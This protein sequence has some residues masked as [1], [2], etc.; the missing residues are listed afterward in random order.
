M[1]GSTRRD[2]AIAGGLTL[3]VALVAAPAAAQTPQPQQPAQLPSTPEITPPTPS[4]VPPPS[5]SVDARG[6]VVQS[7]CPFEDS[8]IRLQLN[9]VKFARPDGSPLQ[10][11][12][13]QALAGLSVP[14]GDQPIRVVCA[15]R[16]QA[17]EA[18]QR[19]GWVASVQIPAQSIET[20]ELTL[21]VVT[22]RITEIRVRGAPGPYRDLLDARLQQLRGL[23]PLNQ[24]DAE[25]LLLLANDVPGLDV[26]L[27]LRPAG[28]QPGDVIGDLLITYRPFAV[29]FNAQNYNSR[30]LGRETGYIRGELYGVTGLSDVL[31]V[32][33]STT[34]DGRE[35][36]IAQAGWRVGLD[37]AGTT[38]EPRIVYAWSRPDLGALKLETE[39][40]ITGFDLARP[41]VRSLNT[42]LSAVLG[43]DYV[44][45]TTVVSTNAAAKTPLN[46]DKLRILYFSLQGS[47]GRRNPDASYAYLVRGELEVRKGLDIF[48][49]TPR[50][51]TGTGA[52][53]SRVDGNSRATVV[54]AD[55]SVEANL[56]RIFSVTGRARGQW[57]DDPLL[58]YEEFSL[59][60]LTVGRGYDPGSNSGDKAVGVTAELGVRLPL[61]TPDVGVQ[62]FGFYDSVWLTNL[63]RNA[64]EVDRNLRSYGGGVR[65]TVLRPVQ[66]YLEA[67]YAHPLDR[68]LSIDKARPTDRFLL[69]LTAKF[70]ARAR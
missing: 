43:F 52:I 59:G 24:R 1:R 55:L 62:A 13:A 17:N 20:G 8:P 36:I 66:L 58:N 28:T 2:A 4:T 5:V 25:R 41:L 29:L 37:G 9:A 18:L 63:D 50:G 16:D 67:T 70:D 48:D 64:T 26:Q 27:S 12:I 38:L 56:N 34:A 30:A 46:L 19:G 35:Q 14:T 69:S 33:G 21:Q 7:T 3:A 61:K 44:D 40:L 49:A 10:P 22:A 68:A 42:N 15:L 6:A 51:T 54:R 23:D 65:V 11:E 31:Y 39:T 32:G 47:T 45:Q 60:N 53:P 57:A